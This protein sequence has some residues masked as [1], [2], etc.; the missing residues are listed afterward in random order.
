MAA[1][2]KTRRVTDPPPEAVKYAYGS[3]GA[4]A[5]RAAC[6]MGYAP[7]YMIGFDGN[8]AGHA[9]PDFGMRKSGRWVAPPWLDDRWGE[10]FEKVR[11]EYPDTPIYL[12]G[13]SPSYLEG[14]FPRSPLEPW[15]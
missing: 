13:E 3:C 9:C 6:H 7:V 4:A 1:L 8:G 5:L 15:S 10:G 14:L 2:K 11:G 12:M